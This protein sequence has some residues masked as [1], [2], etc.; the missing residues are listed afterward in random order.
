MRLPKRARSVR[1]PLVAG[2]CRLLPTGRHVSV[3]AMNTQAGLVP[4]GERER[5]QPAID[6]HQ[7][8]WRVDRGDY[9]IDALLELFGP[10]RLI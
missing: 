4:S 10:Q 3:N 2:C 9:G 7:H 5:V 1:Y 6:A 8:F